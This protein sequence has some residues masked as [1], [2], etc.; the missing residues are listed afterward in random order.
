MKYVLVVRQPVYG[1]QGAFL[2]YQF[3]QALLLA[4]HQISQIFFYQEGVSH[5]NGFVYPANDE[6]NLTQAWQQLS[7]QYQ[8]PLHLCI[9]AAQRRGVVDENSAWNTQQ[10]NLATGFQ[11]AGL[12]EF[13]QA[14][15][16][17]DRVITL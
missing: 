8:V 17:A 16:T 14:L 1:S 3:A 10:A 5:G 7:Q 2:A 15:L 12:G 11:L 4:K 13:S 9:A 6:F